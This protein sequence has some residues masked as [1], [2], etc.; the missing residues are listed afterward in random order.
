MPRIAGHPVG[1]SYRESGIVG[2]A[3]HLPRP[4]KFSP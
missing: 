1:A 4:I 2:R 3:S